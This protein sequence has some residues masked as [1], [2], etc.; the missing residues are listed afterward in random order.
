MVL[1]LIL[2]TATFFHWLK[3]DGTRNLSQL[4]LKIFSDR[5]QTSLLCSLFLCP[6]SFNICKY[7][8][9]YNLFNGRQ[10]L[11]LAHNFVDSF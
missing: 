2:K 6:R 11:D 9:H 8:M 1:N 7:V 5:S 3:W 10:Y 4:Y